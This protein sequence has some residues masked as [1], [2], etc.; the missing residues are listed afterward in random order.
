MNIEVR[1]EGP[2]VT[3]VTSDEETDEEVTTVL[4]PHEALD[5]ILM[6]ERA[7]DIACVDADRIMDEVDAAKGLH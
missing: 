2:C 1:A 4:A 5:L 6:L 3:L 7:C